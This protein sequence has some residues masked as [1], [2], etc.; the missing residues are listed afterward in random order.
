MNYAI[1][2]KKFGKCYNQTFISNLYTI[3][4]KIAF[5]LLPL[6]IF[7]FL[8]CN[9]DTQE[10]DV[11]ID[12]EQVE[13]RVEIKSETLYSCSDGA[14]VLNGVLTDVRDNQNYETV[15]IGQQ[16]WMA[17]NLNYDDGCSDVIWVDD[18]VEGWCG[19]YDDENDNCLTHGLLYQWNAA[20]GGGTT[21]GSQGICPTGWHV[22]SDQE[23]KTLEMF[24]GMTQ[25][26]ADKL[27]S[28][29]ESGNVSSKLKDTNHRDYT[30]FAALPGG[31][32]VGDGSFRN[33]GTMGYFWSSTSHSAGNSW[34][35]HLDWYVDGI[36]RSTTSHTHSFSVRCI[37]D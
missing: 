5:I 20:M 36:D 31:Y 10:G 12:T 3:M 33:F 1:I 9:G 27:G 6:C 29:R 15:K 34:R 24:L 25:D 26:D 30:G 13:D 37:R 8:A 23:W 32:R 35:R 14:G 4:K 2:F 28:G 11:Q 21:E 16:C 7:I 22:P 17:E 18:S 19:C